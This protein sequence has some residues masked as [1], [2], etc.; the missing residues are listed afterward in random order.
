VEE[1][2]LP[3][4][5]NFA[6]STVYLRNARNGEAEM[7][8]FAVQTM[9]ADHTAK[10]AAE[11]L[12]TSGADGDAAITRHRVGGGT[13]IDFSADLG[14]SFY[15][16]PSSRLRRV[17]RNLLDEANALPIAISAPASV[18]GAV[19]RTA[20][21]Q[22]LV[23]LHNCPATVHHQGYQSG[24]DYMPIIPRDVIPV[25]DVRIHLRGVP[26]TAA[27]RLVERPGPLAVERRG[28][29]VILCLHRLDL[30]EIVQIET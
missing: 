2:A 23:H 1:G 28:D 15:Y 7:H 29:C 20:G 3:A 8:G 5:D 27:T 16:A 11:A 4:V 25:C 17:V 22:L 13:V 19:R 30:H 21:G 12:F 9:R 10:P 6:R 18:A 14:A 24:E 26:V